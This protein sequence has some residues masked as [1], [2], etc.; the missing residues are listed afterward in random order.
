MRFTGP[1]QNRQR[2]KTARGIRIVRQN[3]LI[4]KGFI[5]GMVLLLFC[6]NLPGFVSSVNDVVR[7]DQP[8]LQSKCNSLN[9]GSIKAACPLFR[10]IGTFL[11]HS[12]KIPLKV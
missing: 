7:S 3:R 6:E 9:K 2:R 8:V 10:T 5:L 1:D 12:T 4:P 11:G